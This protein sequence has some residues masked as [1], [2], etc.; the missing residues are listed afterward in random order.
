MAEVQAPSTHQHVVIRCTPTACLSA[1]PVHA[2]CK[3]RLAKQPAAA[4]A[5]LAACTAPAG[6]PLRI[7]QVEDIKKD[8]TE[9]KAR[10]REIQ[11]QHERSKTIVRQKEMQKHREEMQVGMPCRHARGKAVSKGT[12]SCLLVASDW[13]C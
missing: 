2:I 11:Q 5:T 10:Q 1:A 6:T 3:P 9:I 4:D 7:P 12:C 13:H 8:L